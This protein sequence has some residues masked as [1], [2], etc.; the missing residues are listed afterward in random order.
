MFNSKFK[1]DD[2]IICILIC[3]LMALHFDTY[4]QFKCKVFH[5]FILPPCKHWYFLQN[6]QI[7]YVSGCGT[8]FLFSV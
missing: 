3:I 8:V 1:S 4:G 6:M 5:T 2:Y 7:D